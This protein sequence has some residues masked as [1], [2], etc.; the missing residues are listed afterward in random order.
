MRAAA[1]F[2]EPG[3]M[4]SEPETA[5]EGLPTPWR[6]TVLPCCRKPAVASA[7][8]HFC[9]KRFLRDRFRFCFS[10]LAA[11]FDAARAEALCQKAQQPSLSIDSAAPH[12]L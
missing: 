12:A 6:L 7:V 10:C 5:P 8:P 3:E 2:A 1:S 9:E 11:C 4:L